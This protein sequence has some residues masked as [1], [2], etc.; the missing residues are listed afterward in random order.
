MK[1]AYLITSLILLTFSTIWMLIR[2]HK[3]HNQETD[4]LDTVDDILFNGFFKALGKILESIQALLQ[5]PSKK[6]TPEWLFLFGL[7]LMI[8]YLN[9]K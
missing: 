1:I 5:K 3:S 7:I 6:N 8:I 9:T 2:D 4:A